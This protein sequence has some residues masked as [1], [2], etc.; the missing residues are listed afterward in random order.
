MVEQD[1]ERRFKSKELSVAFLRECT[2]TR[3][4]EGEKKNKVW[5][6]KIRPN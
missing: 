4:H 2:Q 6:E 3:T 1:E 5:W